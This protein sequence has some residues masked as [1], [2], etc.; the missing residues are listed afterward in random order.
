MDK[1]AQYIILLSSRLQVGK[2]MKRV[3]DLPHTRRPSTCYVNGL[4]D[5]LAWKGADYRYS[6]LPIVGGMAGFG[7]LKFKLAKPPFMVYWGNSPKYLLRE[8]GEV[9]GFKQQVIEG[10]SWKSVS[11]RIRQSIDQGEPVVAGALDMY[12]LSY[13]QDLHTKVHVPIHYVLI[14]GYDDEKGAYLV[15]DCSYDGVQEIPYADLMRSLDVVVPGLSKKNTIRTFRLQARLPAELKVAEKGLKRKA[16]MML[17]PPVSMF[18]IPAMRKLAKDIVNWDCGQCFDHMVAYA[19]MTPPLIPADLK[20]CNGLRFEQAKLLREL[21]QEY[22][23]RQWT[24]ASG[25]FDDSGELIVELCRH[26]VEHDGAKCGGILTEIA[27]AEEKAYQ[28]ITKT[29]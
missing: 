25:L 6:L 27:D 12:Y 22:H 20:E 3:L 9:V 19:G 29:A 16:E 2:S 21:G 7:Y 5:M 17:R 18:G 13:Y 14:V 8:L 11:E 10:R 26:G 1:R 28:V 15:H 23:R 24:E 4:Y